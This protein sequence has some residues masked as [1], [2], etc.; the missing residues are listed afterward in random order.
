MITVALLDDHELVRLGFVNLF[1]CESDFHIKF[2]TS[3]AA[4]LL[5]WLESNHADIIITD[6][7]LRSSSGYELI[8]SLK[9]QGNEAKIIVL[10][11]H[12]SDPYVSKAIDTGAL[13]YV[14]KNSAPDELF[15][16]IRQ[17]LSGSVYFSS[18]VAKNV[19]NTRSSKSYQT[20]QLLTDRER[21]VFELLANGIEVKRIASSLDI[22]TKTV[23]VHRANILNKLNVS[24]SFDLTKIALKLGFIDTQTLIG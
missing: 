14:S 6:L 5:K 18:D 21:Q 17:V 23:H 10:S 9:S 12:D 7:T 2:H 15:I 11:M 22:A 4:S 1:A 16:A 19:M 8:N 13:G 20:I 3:D 24:N